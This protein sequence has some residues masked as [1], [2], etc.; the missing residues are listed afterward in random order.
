M[1]ILKEPEKLAKATLRGKKAAGITFP[2]LKLYYK[3]T[4]IKTVWY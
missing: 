1:E 3:G 4:I 2:Y